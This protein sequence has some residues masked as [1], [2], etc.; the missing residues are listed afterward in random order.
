MIVAKKNTQLF[1][2]DGCIQLAKAVI[3]QLGGCELQELLR[4]QGWEKRDRKS[5]QIWKETRNNSKSFLFSNWNSNKK[6]NFKYSDLWTLHN[7]DFESYN[8]CQVSYTQQ[9]LEWTI[10]IW[11]LFFSSEEKG[12]EEI[13]SNLYIM[14]SNFLFKMKISARIVRMR[15]LLNFWCNQRYFSYIGMIFNCP[16]DIENIIVARSRFVCIL[17]IEINIISLLLY[18]CHEKIKSGREIRSCPPYRED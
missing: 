11:I 16:Y 10:E 14:Y 9:N 5:R 3:R 4:Q 1:I 15:I 2:L 13:K 17:I 8:D 7:K 18:V 6:I 12:R